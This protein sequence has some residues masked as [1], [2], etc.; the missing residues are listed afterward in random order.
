MAHGT[1]TLHGEELELDGETARPGYVKIWASEELAE[2]DGTPVMTGLVQVDIETDGTWSLDLPADDGT[3]TP[4]GFHF[5]AQRRFDSGSAVD[6]KT[7]P[8]QDAGA[9]VNLK[10]VQP[11]TPGTPVVQVLAK[12]DKGDTG[13]TGPAGAQ[14]V[15]GP[16]GAT[17]PTGAQGPAG[18]TGATGP[19]GATGAQGS[20]GASGP[21]G[22]PGPSVPQ[23][24]GLM[25]TSVQSLYSRT[26]P[27]GNGSPAPTPSGFYALAK[28]P[29]VAGRVW[30]L[31]IDY[32]VLIFSDNGGAS[33][34][35]PAGITPAFT[36]AIHQMLFTGTHVWLVTGGNTSK[37]GQVWRSPLPAANGTGMSWT[38]MFDLT[39]PPNSL[40][41]GVNSFFRPQCLAVSGANVWLLEYGTTVT[42]GPSLYYSSDTGV[43]W[44]KPKTWANAKHGHAVHAVGGVPLVMLG[45]AGA[46]FTDLG[47][48]RCTNAAGTGTW[49]QISAYGEAKGGNTLYGINF[50]P[51][52]VQGK[53]MLAVEYDGALGLGPL[54]FPDSGSTSTIWPMLQ[55]FR[56]PPAYYGTMRCLTLTSEGNLMWV[57]TAEN[58]AFGPTDTVWISAAPFTTAVLLDSFATSSM[59]LGDPIEDGDYVWLGYYRCH[60]EKFVGQ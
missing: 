55:T 13:D 59:F 47:L 9:V 52:T 34:T 26:K 29:S 25:G 37:S 32:S 44:S 6:T 35:A 49:T 31:S 50:Q 2:V 27:V 30:M 21:Q 23:A 46:T 40:V 7:V 53:A 28:D 5:F 24:G 11:P 60:K 56:L 43:N 36:G 38:L 10:D 16:T 4:S 41:A 39:T 58:G 20:A 1:F 14:G 18:P 45:D 51:I 57:Q 48:W 22:I 42:G 8:G 19:A 54:L 17:G 3:V 33:I 12:G 15:A